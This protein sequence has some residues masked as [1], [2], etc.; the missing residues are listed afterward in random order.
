[1]GAIKD[2]VDL[3][4]QLSESTN[5]RKVANELLKI[6]TLTLRLQAE[7][8]TLHESNI[9]LREECLSLKEQILLLKNQIQESSTVAGH[10]PEGVP[11]CP[12]C[13]TTNKPFFMRAVGDDFA[14]LLNASHECPQC[15]YTTK[16][17]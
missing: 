15:K 11:A 5:D 9:Q 17:E 13:S 16:I 8:A 3:T 12:N 2:I 6:Q 7:Q 4:T 14:Q 10:V 1:M